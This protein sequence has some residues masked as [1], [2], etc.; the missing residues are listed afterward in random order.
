VAL[1]SQIVAVLGED[2]LLLPQQIAQSLIANDQ[3]KYYFA[4]LQ[5]ARANA[6]RPT[7]PVQD[8]KAERLA[9]R[10]LDAT[11]D[12]TVG[13]A[14]RHSAG[15]YRI[16]QAARVLEQ[17]EA[18]L[19]TMIACLP[20]I[21]RASL[22]SR[23]TKLKPPKIEADTI[24]GALIDTI[25]SGNRKRGD[26]LHL[27]VMDAHKAIN[28]RQ[29]ETAVETLSGAHVHNLT[30]KSRPLVEAF[31]AGLN[32]TA[33]LKFDHPGLGTTATEHDGRVLIQNDIGTTDAHVLVVRIEKR[34]TTLTYTDIHKARLAF[35]QSLFSAFEVDWANADPQENGSLVNKSYLLT[36]GTYVASSD[37]D[38][39]RYLDHLGSR[40]VF[41]I[42]W[43]KARK[44]LQGFVSK[45]NAIEVLRWAANHDFGHR[46]LLEIGGEKLLAEAVE[47]AAGEALHYGDRLDNL[48]GDERA[49]SFLKTACER[50]C[51]GLRQQHSRRIIADEIKADLRGEFES[52]GL[53][54]FSVAARHAACGFD[55][56]VTLKEALDDLNANAGDLVQL[57]RRAAAWEK[58]ADQFLNDARSD[59]A[60]FNRPRALLAFFESAD[61]AVDEL[62]EAASLAELVALVPQAQRPLE[63]LQQLGDTALACAQ[64][65]VKCIECAA[66]I[67]RSDVRDDLDDFL[68][69]LDRLI[70]LEHKAD[71]LM[72]LTRRALVDKVTDPRAI[73]LV[74]QLARALE[75]ATDAYA[76]AGQSLRGYLMEE[77]LA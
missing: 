56:A 69:S 49:I 33:P 45:S 11:L 6:D 10:I 71:D 24:T 77:V 21:E 72:R 31:M 25:T 17:I 55:I 36:T 2:D 62:E 19:D 27:V 5:M 26:S 28:R 42:D 39:A 12:D 59:I 58:R 50:A 67:S 15:S 22:T 48:V 75:A 41:L 35:F 14:G 68:F 76:H 7:V 20:A 1:K 51:V 3:I 54:I 37:D 34:T 61:D 18:G 46:A 63:E 38:L 43:N 74:D 53:A 57:A 30:E 52:T 9:S 13:G 29:A 70:G 4:L 32:R 60:R 44:R 8:L 65:L 47:F 40:I 23:I 66:A 16:P 64:E 73:Y